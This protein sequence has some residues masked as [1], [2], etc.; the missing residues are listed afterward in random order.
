MIHPR[1][2][3]RQVEL[4]ALLRLEAARRLI[5]AVVGG[6]WSPEPELLAHIGL[7]ARQAQRRFEVARW[8]AAA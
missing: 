4:E 2:D 6:Q 8:E 1:S 5:D 3:S 7:L